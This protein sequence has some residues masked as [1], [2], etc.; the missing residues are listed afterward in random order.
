[1][2]PQVFHTCGASTF[3]EHSQITIY[4]PLVQLKL[5]DNG[6]FPVWQPVG[7]S[8]N[9][10]TKQIG[11]ELGVLTSHTGTLDPMAEGVVIVL[12]GE[13]RLQKIELAS[14]KKTYEFE[15]AFGIRT[16]SFDGL[17]IITEV[18]LNNFLNISKERIEDILNKFVGP[19][20]QT[21]PIYSAIKY[22]GKKLFIHANSGVVIDKLP[23]KSGIIFDIKLLNLKEK[24]LSETIEETINKISAVEGNLRQNEIILSWKNLLSNYSNSGSQQ[25]YVAKIRVEN[26]RGLY[27]RSLSQDICKALGTVG[28][29]TSLVRTA[30]GQYT[31]SDTYLS[32]KI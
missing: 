2:A 29:V 21:V 15:L 17:G 11:E 30:N 8:T 1:M 16:D 32:D 31:K 22:Q 25:I 5:P 28:F 12:C 14:W 3:F 9:H 20:T 23:E 7:K 10:L 27:V 24:L 26:S 13:K 18:K 19:Y 4:T 6:I